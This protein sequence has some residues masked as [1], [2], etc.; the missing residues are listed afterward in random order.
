MTGH[1]I[2][3]GCRT[4]QGIWLSQSLLSF[5]MLCFCAVASQMAIA[6]EPAWWTA[7]KQSCGLPSGLAY[8]DWN[9]KCNSSSGGVPAGGGSAPQ[10]KM[11]EQGAAAVGNA[12]GKAIGEAIFSGPQQEDPGQ[13]AAAKAAA[14]EWQQR[15]NAA[16]QLNNSGIYLFKQ[17][18]YTGAINE[19]QQA[20]IQTPGDPVII[21][22]IA[23]AKQQIKDTQTANKNSNALKKLLGGAA[24]SGN[25]GQNGALPSS[26]ADSSGLGLVNLDSAPI[27]TNRPVASPG[28]EGRDAIKGQLR[29]VFDVPP[30]PNPLVQLPEN[31]DI[32][33]LGQ[34][35]APPPSQW[36]GPKRPAGE[37]KLVNPLDQEQQEKAEAAR[38]FDT[39]FAQP[40][41]LDD[42]LE[43]QAPFEE[44]K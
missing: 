30:P 19:F 44:L 2:L 43:K 28:S 12:I 10:Q 9:G 37:P 6:G 31:K 22:N 42:I 1:L 38:Q 14:F 4:R 16:Q 5:I 33:L 24:G 32:E 39:I 36:P 20:L 26:P 13:A 34:P 17:K 21:K 18:N 41:G 15:R 29:G 3:F 27:L 40:G 35:P 11:M 7:Q 23:T 25:Q 8:N